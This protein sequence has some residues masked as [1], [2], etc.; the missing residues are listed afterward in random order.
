[1]F[2]DKPLIILVILIAIIVLISAANSLVNG[3][4]GAR[5]I[6]IEGS[7]VS[8]MIDNKKI[9]G[10]LGE[11]L[12]KSFLVDSGELVSANTG[13]FFVVPMEKVSS[14][15]NFPEC[16]SLDNLT[17]KDN[18]TLVGFI[19]MNS[20]VA[21]E[22]KKVADLHKGVARIIGSELKIK[23]NKNQLPHYFICAFGGYYFIDDVEIVE[24]RYQNKNYDK[25]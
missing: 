5:N 21:M 2:K 1:M 18:I 12:T 24:E 10:E 16:G 9:T 15:P 11:N 4:R 19:A 3:D 14:F 13:V 23:G 22:L 20:T 25:F 6:R 8:L 17:Y 7:R